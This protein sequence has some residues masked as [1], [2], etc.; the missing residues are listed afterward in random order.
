MLI[1]LFVVDLVGLL[2]ITWFCL[3]CVLVWFWILGVVLFVS[4]WSAFYG[5]VR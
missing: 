4:F 3:G 5:H 1:C 2:F